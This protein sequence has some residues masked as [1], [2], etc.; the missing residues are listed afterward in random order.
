M[1]RFLAN[2]FLGPYLL[3]LETRVASLTQRVSDLSADRDRLN[4]ALAAAHSSQLEDRA[5]AADWVAVS[6]GN[7]PL[8]NALNLP[9]PAADPYTPSPSGR[10]RATIK[11][12]EQEFLAKRDR[13]INDRIDERHEPAA[14]DRASAPGQAGAGLGSP[15]SRPS[16]SS[17]V[18]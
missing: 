16:P 12:L 9:P 14:N 8:Y 4:A 18:S 5:R 13:A 1:R 2:L 10:K 6:S 15:D 11:Q 3:D 7:L 17:P